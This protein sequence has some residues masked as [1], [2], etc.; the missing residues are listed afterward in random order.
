MSNSNKINMVGEKNNL[1]LV[2]V[3][4]LKGFTTVSNTFI[5]DRSLSLKAKGLLLLV[6]SLDSDSW[7]FSVSGLCGI[8]KEGETSVRSAIGELVE[9]GYCKVEKQ[10][11]KDG[12][13]S[14]S[15]YVFYEE[16][17]VDSP[18]VENPHVDNQGQI[19]NNINKIPN[20]EEERNSKE[21]K[22]SPKEIVDFWNDNTDGY[23]KVKKMTNYVENAIQARINEGYS[24]DDIK[25]AILLCN[26]LGDFYKGKNDTH[27]KADFFWLMKNTKGN[28]DKILSGALHRSGIE[29]REYAMLMENYGSGYKDI[30]HPVVEENGVIRWDEKIKMYRI[31]GKHPMY[32]KINDGYTDDSRPDGAKLASQYGM[33]RWNAFLKEWSQFF[34]EKR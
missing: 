13:F 17:R 23:A 28:F 26:S 19:N 29:Q 1:D 14:S 25:K 34:D 5:H 24:V 27:W 15:L 20:K 10:R 4:H 22:F 7:D 11:D 32:H 3:R 31:I 9:H 18:Y 16:P 12:H 8:V 6:M 30:Y 21:R 2:K 33:F